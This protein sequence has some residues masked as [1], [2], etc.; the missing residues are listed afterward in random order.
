MDFE[1]ATLKELKNK[2]YYLH[3]TRDDAYNELLDAQQNL[4]ECIAAN[5]KAVYGKSVELYEKSV[6]LCEENIV[7]LSAA[8]LR[9]EKVIEE[10][11]K[12]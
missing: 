7:A 5:E 4:E 12:S 11:E 6:R 2:L 1:K 3:D 10:R 9:L 8:I